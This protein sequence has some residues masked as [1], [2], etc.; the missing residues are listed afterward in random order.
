MT[1]YWIVSF[2]MFLGRDKSDLQIAFG[3][4]VGMF[5][6][7][8]PFAT[9]H[10]FIIM[11]ILVIT[12]INILAA[13]I[14]WLSFSV[15]SFACS[16]GIETFGFWFLTSQRSLLPWLARAYH[17]PIIPFTNFN[18]SSVMGGTLL[19]ILLTVP[20]LGISCF[21][22]KRY[23]SKLHGFWLSTRLQRAYA[24]AKRFTD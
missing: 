7:L 5:L 2:F 22:S 19:A 16:S 21:I 4:I 23:R 6:G 13:L 12:R 15:F 11:G 24:H 3:V 9:L 20:V 8:I 10:H 18:H 1:V 17:A 14:S